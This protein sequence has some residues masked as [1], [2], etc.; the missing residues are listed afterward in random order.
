MACYSG[1]VGRGEYLLQPLL[2]VSACVCLRYIGISRSRFLVAEYG[3]VCE[4]V[5]C[6]LER[7]AAASASTEFVEADLETTGNQSMA[8]RWACSLCL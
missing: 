4:C 3:F 6:T 8:V 1:F 5:R 7:K 2:A